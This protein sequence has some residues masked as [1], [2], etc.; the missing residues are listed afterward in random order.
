MQNTHLFQDSSPRTTVMNF[1]S[2][3]Q[4]HLHNQGHKENSLR[5]KVISIATGGGGNKESNQTATQSKQ[6]DFP[7]TS[8]QTLSKI[9]PIT[10]FRPRN[11]TF[12][13]V[14]NGYRP[15]DPRRL[16]LGGKGNMD[17]SRP[18]THSTVLDFVDFVDLY[19]SFSLRCRKDMKDLF[20]Q[21]ATE[22]PAVERPMP[23]DLLHMLPPAKYSGM[24][25][26]HQISNFFCP[27]M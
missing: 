12:N 27:H 24:K 15:R 23:K 10:I 19:K 18:I 9:G 20:E 13:F 25:N 7:N 22:K 4:E 3:F 1:Q 21:F 26:I 14:E 2:H 17:S 16:S 6:T 5:Q 8:G 11:L